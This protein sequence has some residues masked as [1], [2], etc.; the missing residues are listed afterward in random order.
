[1]SN[2][3]S[4]YSEDHVR[5][6]GSKRYFFD[7]NTIDRSV[8]GQDERLTFTRH[9]FATTRTLDNVYGEQVDAIRK[10]LDIFLN[11]PEWYAKHGIPRTFALL[12]HGTPGC[13]KTSTAR[14]IANVT[15]RH[16]MNINMGNITT[17]KQLKELLLSDT[18]IVSDG[19]PNAKE[20]KYSIP[21]TQRVFII[22][23]MDCQG[24]NTIGLR[25]DI[26]VKRDA[27]DNMDMYNRRAYRDPDKL[28]LSTFLNVLDGVLEVPGRMIIITSNYPERLD[29]AL[30]RPGRID[31][32]VKY[33][34]MSST[35]IRRMY[36]NFF[37]QDVPEYWPE[38]KSGRWTPAEVIQK[39]F[40]YI[41]FPS[42]AYKSIAHDVP[43]STCPER[44]L[45]REE[46]VGILEGMYAKSVTG[47]KIPDM[48]WTAKDVTDVVLLFKDDPEGAVKK[49]SFTPDNIPSLFG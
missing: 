44:L 6:I 8:R 21:V 48:T 17:K 49:L 3:V 35:E 45:P 20:T 12:L 46:V 25:R 13:G 40:Q 4:K 34:K 18:I 36:K 37:K 11:H 28:D 38:V 43:T 26:Q 42:D 14:A 31:L 15:G 16:V 29:P 41:D 5:R 23:D 24:K 47:G 27:E 33:D 1:V 9:D 39:F 19:G 7:Q 2:I 32:I 10:R 22:E 30:V